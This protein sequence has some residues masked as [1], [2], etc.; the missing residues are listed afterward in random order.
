MDKVGPVLVS[1]EGEPGV[2]SEA[3]C[4]PKEWRVSTYDASESGGSIWLLGITGDSRAERWTGEL[5]RL[6]EGDSEWRLEGTAD[7]QEFP[8]CVYL[9]PG[10]NSMRPDLIC[11]ERG[12]LVK[13]A[14]VLGAPP[15]IESK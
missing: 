11:F 6:N 8:T 2:Y 10:T 7:F 15:E 3:P 13:K 14:W 9:Q 12:L 5:M 4:P 1:T